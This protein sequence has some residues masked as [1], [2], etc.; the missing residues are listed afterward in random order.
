MKLLL[1][2]VGVA[3]LFHAAAAADGTWTD[4][5]PHRA[6]VAAVGGLS[7]HYL[8][9]GGPRPPRRGRVAGPPVLLLVHGI[10]STAHDFDGL[11]PRLTDSFRVLA[12]TRR[13]H[14][15][16]S[17]PHAGYELDTLA[18]DLAGF[19]DAVGV[20]RAFVA[21]H[22]MGGLDVAAFAARYPERCAGVLLL[23]ATFD[24]PA[25]TALGRAYPVPPPAPPM[26]PET[27]SL[28]AYLRWYRGRAGVWSAASEASF[29]E[30]FVLKDG[31]VAHVMPEAAGEA[32]G[33]LLSTAKQEYAAFRAP[34]LYLYAVPE[35]R[36]RFP[37]LAG[38]REGLAR[39][40]VYH[41]A[42]MALRREDVSRF[43][44]GGP[45]R[46]AV[47]FPRTV[48]ELFIQRPAAVARE[49]RRFLAAEQAL[50]RTGHPPRSQPGRSGEEP[51]C[52][53]S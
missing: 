39:A 36:Q 50:A 34:A 18:A 20:R 28:E 48:H 29:R 43:L 25:V 51:P 16:S 3:V 52:A 10:G 21:G 12:V 53:P 14:G 46:R 5:S 9:W 38:D 1:A 33:H 24:G 17:H 45:S 13:G 49:V 26:G 42:Q 35:T 11:A 30:S 40:E 22:S 15:R 27:A 47:R 31:R 44:A 7:L 4:R 32:F 2:A 41:R 19:L 23:D 8:D 37:Y 6:G